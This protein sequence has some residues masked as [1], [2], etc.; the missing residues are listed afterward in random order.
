MKICFF[1]LTRGYK[2]LNMY[3]E[4]ILRNKSL[5][6]NVLNKLN[7]QYEIIL[8]HE[9]NISSAQQEYI[10]DE[11]NIK[12]KFINV[13]KEFE[14]KGIQNHF[15]L[16]KKFNHGYRSMCK[17]NYF[18]VWKYLSE[19]EYVIRV[20][21]DVILQQF[22][23]KEL[24]KIIDRKEVFST[25]SLTEESHKLTNKTLPFY[26]KK[27]LQIDN[28][29][30]YNHN[31]PYTN[32]YITRTDFWLHESIQIVLKKIAGSSWSYI[33]RWG[34]LPIIGCLLNYMNIKVL[35]LK[36]AEYFHSSHN[37]TVKD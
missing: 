9:G 23:T 6:K 32:F 33:F 14:V 29:D 36:K 11:S 18:G 4:L 21:E 3:S 34:D 15:I 7:I 13:K 16:D 2:D 20:D 17:F 30:F 35:I 31:F 27:I 24:E 25:I 19:F 37:V 12:I 28:Y 5:Q 22:D 26:L 10:V 8:F 1:A